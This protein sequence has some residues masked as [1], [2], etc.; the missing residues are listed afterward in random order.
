[1]RIIEPESK[2]GAYLIIIIG[3]IA[4][5]CN[6]YI[7]TVAT[8]IILLGWLF[9][10]SSKVINPTIPNAVVSPINGKITKIMQQHDAIEII[11]KPKFNGRIYAPS[12]LLNI[13]IMQHHGFYFY[14]NSKLSE[15]LG[16]YSTLKANTIFKDEKL[17][18][19]IKVIP[20]LLRICG[21][22]FAKT[23]ALFLEKIGFL[24]NGI[25]HIHIQ[26]K[27]IQPL[28]EQNTYVRGGITPLITL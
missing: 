27:N 16:A 23:D 13:E 2:Q 4:L 19:K 11:I 7:L 6:F 25:L 8:F 28:V 10:C 21:L 1:M 26:G 17:E 24:N 22:R 14:R 20:R 15:E 18:I 9:F 5:Y 12:D 3:L